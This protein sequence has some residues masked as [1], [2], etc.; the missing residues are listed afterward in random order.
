MKFAL[1]QMGFPVDE[2]HRNAELIAAAGY[3]GIEPNLTA[4]GPLWDED[5][6]AAFA[7]QLDELDL[8]VTGIATTLHWDRQLASSDEATRAAGLDVGERMIE[9]ADTLDA[10]A[11]LVVPGVVGESLPYDKVYDRALNSVRA[12]ATVGAEYDITICLENVWN[13]FLLSPIE[14]AEFVDRASASGPVGM[15]FDVGNVR[16][17]GHP[18]QW[19]RILG[20]R[21]ERV[22]V[23]D[24]RTDVDTM[25]AFT[26]PLEGDVDWDAVADALADIGYD[27]W[28]TAEVPPYRTAPKRML[29]R[30]RSDLAY[31]FA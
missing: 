9:L 24:Y 22:H 7:D 8:S 20:D 26:Y 17:F 3:D 5:S 12:L 1:N 13:D 18:E 29:P 16:R 10:G 15:Y 28:I 6:V 2:L 19:I 30:V 11:V 21:I 14:F 4:D 27:G 25:D 23:K 31:L